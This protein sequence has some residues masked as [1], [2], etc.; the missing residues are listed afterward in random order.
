MTDIN[1]TGMQDMQKMLQEKYKDKWR[2]LCPEIARDKLLWM[3][4]EAGE[5][6][7][8]IK[9]EGDRAIVNNGAVRHHFIEELCDT[10]MYFNDVALC[11]GITPEEMSAVY[12][13]K[14]EIN[15]GRWSSEEA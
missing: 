7:D 5:A 10:L 3:I 8:I 2:A 14:H 1:F 9:K 13:E 12:I 4:I 6:A 15:M 11:Y